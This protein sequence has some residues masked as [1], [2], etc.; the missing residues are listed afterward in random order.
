MAAAAEPVARAAQRNNDTVCVY[1]RVGK[2]TIYTRS[3]VRLRRPATDGNPIRQ[4]PTDCVC[5]CLLWINARE[6]RYCMSCACVCGFLLPVLCVCV[7]LAHSAER[8]SVSHCPTNAHTL[9]V[10]KKRHT[11]THPQTT[12]PRITPNRTGQNRHTRR[13]WGV[14]VSVHNSCGPRCP[15]QFGTIKVMRTRFA[16]AQG[17][18]RES[19]ALRAIAFVRLNG[20]RLV[21]AF[22]RVFR[23]KR[24]HQQ[25]QQQQLQHQHHQ[26]QRKPTDAREKKNNS[27]ANQIDNCGAIKMG[28]I[29]PGNRLDTDNGILCRVFVFVINSGLLLLLLLRKV[30]SKTIHQFRN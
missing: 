21:R 5:L 9:Q 17:T 6:M 24:Q 8:P 14:R 22:I 23:L 30:L 7:L 18:T 13:R 3:T 28:G 25:Q 10:Q 29:M 20:A 11:H 2:N 16:G 4:H 19:T 15:I 12:Q 1:M 27:P 26:Q